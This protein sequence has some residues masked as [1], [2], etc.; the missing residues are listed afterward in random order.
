MRDGMG[1]LDET[2]LRA[3]KEIVV[4]FIEMGRISPVTFSENFKNIYH[5]VNETVKK[6]QQPQP[7]PVLKT[8][9]AENKRKIRK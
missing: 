7:D 9:A 6:D 1:S 5:T 8:T 2:I 4:K 3:S